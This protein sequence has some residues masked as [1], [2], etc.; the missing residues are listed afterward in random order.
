MLLVRGRAADRHPAAAAAASSL[1]R[2][3]TSSSSPFR[4]T[5]GVEHG[6]ADRTEDIGN[7]PDAAHARLVP[8][9]S[10]HLQRAQRGWL[11]VRV[12]GLR[13]I[14]ARPVV[15]LRGAAQGCGP[16]AVPRSRRVRRG[17]DHRATRTAETAFAS[18]IAEIGGRDGKQTDR[19]IV[20]IACAARGVSHRSTSN[21]RAFGRGADQ[22]V[23]SV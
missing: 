8:G 3:M 5:Q 16:A 22:P 4:R 21:G 15:D 14:S 11:Q 10:Q 18:E 6:R 13:R 1:A 17:R 23:W 7:G 2:S 20:E 9:A 19:L 12:S